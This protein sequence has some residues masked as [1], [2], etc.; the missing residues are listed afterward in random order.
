MKELN[1]DAIGRCVVAKR[2]IERL[3]QELSDRQMAVIDLGGVCF[4]GTHLVMQDSIVERAASLAV[5]TCRLYDAI[6]SQALEYNHWASPLRAR[7]GRV[8]ADLGYS[9]S[10]AAYRHGAKRIVCSDQQGP[11]P[12]RHARLKP[13]VNAAAAIQRP[14]PADSV[15]SIEVKG[16]AIISLVRVGISVVTAAAGM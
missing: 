8:P 3:I 11:G 10:V 12:C 6:H 15:V 9:A 7:P 13:A 2:N 1:Y 16:G 14:I 5:D 4:M